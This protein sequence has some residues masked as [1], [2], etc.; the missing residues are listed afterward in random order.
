MFL[1]QVNDNLV[2]FTLCKHGSNENRWPLFVLSFL[3]CYF[4]KIRIMTVCFINVNVSEK[5]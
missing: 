1:F 3:F 4:L 5:K 2:L